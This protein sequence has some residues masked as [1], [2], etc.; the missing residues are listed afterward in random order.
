MVPAAVT[1]ASVAD[2]LLSCDCSPQRVTK[3]EGSSFGALILWPVAMRITAQSD[4]RIGWGEAVEQLA[5]DAG[6]GDP[7]RPMITLLSSQP[8][9]IST[10]LFLVRRL[11]W[12][13]CR[14]SCRADQRIELARP[15][16]RQVVPDFSTSAAYVA[17][18]F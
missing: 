16:F 12:M 8:A 6:Q 9:P 17:S 4:L 10:G 1:F 14:S 2:T 11:R 5:F 18:G 15:S 3:P 7:I 13:T